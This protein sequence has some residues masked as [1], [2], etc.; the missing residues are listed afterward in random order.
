MLDI[1]ENPLLYGTDPFSQEKA[2]PSRTWKSATRLKCTV[3]GTIR[4]L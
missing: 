4:Q 2:K 3:T 1:R